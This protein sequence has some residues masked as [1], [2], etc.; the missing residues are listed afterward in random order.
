MTPTQ[1]ASSPEHEI[2]RLDDG[3]SFVMRPLRKDDLAALQR[4]FARLTPDEIRFR[5]LQYARELPDSI[6]A[7]VRDLDAARLAAFVI[8]DGG[9]IRAVADLHIDPPDA[10][11]AE[12]GLIVGQA[13][14]GHGLGRRL[15][16]RLLL[17]AKRRGLASVTGC[18]SG[19]NAR[20]LRLCQDLGGRIAPVAADPSLK[21]V[22]FTPCDNAT[23]C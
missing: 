17:E 15:M 4:A 19:D 7:Q 18:V 22:R 6:A 2:I 21:S 10:D 12:F 9:E 8:D 13:V 14:S 23:G 3:R 11:Y 5:F 20:M 16:Q 1:A